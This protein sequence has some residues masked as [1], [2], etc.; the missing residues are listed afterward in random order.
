MSAITPQTE[1][2]LLKCPLEEDNKHQLTF[3]N[4]TAQYNYFNGLTHLTADNFTYQRKDSIIRFPEHIDNLLGYNYVMYQNEAYIDKWFYAFITNME[5]VN[6]HMTNITIKTD[7]FQTW[8]FDIVYKRSFI[9]REHVNDDTVSKHTVPE[10]LETGEYRCDSIGT[11]YLANSTYIIIGATKEPEEIGLNMDRYYNGIFSGCQYI[12]FDSTLG[13]GNYLRAMDELG[14]GDAVVNVFLAPTGLCGTLTWNTIS[15]DVGGGHTISTKCA[16]IPMSSSATLLYTSLTIT[17]PA[18]INGYSPKNNKLFVWPYN[19]FYI[20]NNAGQDIEYKYEDFVNNTVQF[21]TY[22]SLTPGC[23]I[24]CYPI[25]YKNYTDVSGK[26]HFNS[27]I[28]CN[29]YP[30]C[31]WSTDLYKNWATQNALNLGFTT[32]GS[33]TAI[34]GGGIMMATG[35]GIPVGLGLMASGVGMAANTVREYYQHSFTPPQANGN[36]NSGDVAYS[37]DKMGVQY[38]KMTI[39]KEYAEIIDNYFSTYGYKV[40]VVKLP[41]VTGRTNWNFVKTIDCNLE[42]NIPQADIDEIKKMFNNGVTF[43]HNP[44]YFLDYSQSNTIVT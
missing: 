4:A 43:W 34:V 38:F 2:R 16:K 44:T 19:Y 25:N 37:A 1:L 31:S 13:A 35:F 27:G 39:R 36:A 33:A 14:I 30:V 15:I 8:Q 41:N 20:S 9:E 12:A 3:S 11:L 24:R 5:Y 23:S 10:Q 7:C 28:T 17:S 18:T 32:V 40:N 21:K 26:E 42:G 6:D 29:K 22:G